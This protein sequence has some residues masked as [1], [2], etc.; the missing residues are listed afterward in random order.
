LEEGFGLS[1]QHPLSIELDPYELLDRLTRLQ[2]AIKNYQY[3]RSIA[4]K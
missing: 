2:I 3:H 1:R 4:T